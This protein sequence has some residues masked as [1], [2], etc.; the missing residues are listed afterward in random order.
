MPDFIVVDKDA[1][2]TPH[3]EVL[4]ISA[5][6][7]VTGCNATAGITRKYEAGTWYYQ[8]TFNYVS[9]TGLNR[10][11]TGL[12]SYDDALDYAEEILVAD[13]RRS[14]ALALTLAQLDG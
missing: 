4:V 14:Q 7:S 9:K 1:I 13:S 10:N 5:S 11:F 2:A 3:I 8:V 12:T 6:V